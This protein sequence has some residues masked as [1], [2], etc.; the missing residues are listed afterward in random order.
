MAMMVRGE[1]FGTDQ[2]LDHDLVHEVWGDTET[3]E[4]RGKLRE[5]PGLGRD[6]FIDQVVDYAQRQCSPVRAGLAVGHIKRAVQTGGGLPLESGLALERE[7]QAKL[8]ASEDA[9]EGMS[10]FVEKRKANFTGC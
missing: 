3:R 4:V 8:F 1:T 5:V 7:L 2:A 9:R 10:A 6:A